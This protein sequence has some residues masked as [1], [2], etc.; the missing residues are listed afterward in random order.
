MTVHMKFDV[1]GTPMLV[2]LGENG[3]RLFRPGNEG[4]RSELHIVVPDFIGE[5]EIQQYL[6]DLFHESATP[7]HPCVRRVED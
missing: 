4:K 5:N 1:Y 7:A 2:E 6:D 3:W